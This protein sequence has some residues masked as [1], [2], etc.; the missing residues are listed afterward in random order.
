MENAVRFATNDDLHGGEKVQF[1]VGRLF[2][3]LA[4]R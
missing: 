2:S 3:Q 1:A 4:Y